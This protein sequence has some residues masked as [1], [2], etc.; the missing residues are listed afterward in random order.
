MNQAQKLLKAI[1]E[2][3]IA[4]VI[5]VLIVLALAVAAVGPQT[6][7]DALFAGAAE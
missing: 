7:W 5:V 6:V 3:P 2:M 1:S 4:K